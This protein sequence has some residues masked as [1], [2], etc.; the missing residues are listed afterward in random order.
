MRALRIEPELRPGLLLEQGMA[1]GEAHH[2]LAGRGEPHRPRAHQQTL[3]Q[4][5]LELLDPLAHRRRG[6]ALAPRGGLERARLRDEAERL[7]E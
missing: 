6:H 2:H 1:A 7:G 5:L 4:L 3:T